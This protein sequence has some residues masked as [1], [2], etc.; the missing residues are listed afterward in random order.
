MWD[1]QRS[2]WLIKSLL[3]IQ[4]LRGVF[5]EDVWERE[6]VDMPELR[7]VDTFAD[8]ARLV[9]DMLRT[10][11]EDQLGSG[12]PFEQVMPLERSSSTS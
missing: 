5:A 8:R 10:G 4:L 3:W 9:S 12:L 7:F 2:E 6:S 11:R 1:E